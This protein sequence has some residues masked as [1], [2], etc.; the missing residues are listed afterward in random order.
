MATA[1][2]QSWHYL[3]DTHSPWILGDGA[4][5]RG[6]ELRCENMFSLPIDHTLTGDGQDA[7]RHANKLGRMADSLRANTDLEVRNERGEGEEQA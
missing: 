3:A 5:R 7:E 1:A 4:G 6:H 2:G